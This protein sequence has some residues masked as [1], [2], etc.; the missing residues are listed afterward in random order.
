MDGFLFHFA[1]VKYI[2]VKDR[3][4]YVVAD[5]FSGTIKTRYK[6]LNIY[7]HARS[8]VRCHRSFIVNVHH[9]KEIY[10]DTHSTFMLAMDDGTSE[11][12]SVN[13]TQVIFVNFRVLKY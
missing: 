13:R 10:P 1:D 6:N 11:F 8:F 9:I 4:T 3:K 5:G 7:C 2:E 12:Q